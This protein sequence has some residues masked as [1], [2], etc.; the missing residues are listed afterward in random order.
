MTAD[1]RPGRAA[2]GRLQGRAGPLPSLRVARLPLG[3][4]HADLPQAEEARGRHLGLR[5]APS[6]ASKAGSSTRTTAPPAISAVRLDDLYQVYL[7]ADPHYSG[8]VTVPVLW[9]KKSETIVS[10]ESAEIIRMFNSA[11]DEFGRRVARLLSGRRCAARSTRSTTC[12][13]ETVNN[14]VYKAGFATT[15]E[16]YEEAFATLFE[17]L[18]ELEQRLSR[19]RYL[20]GDPLTEAD[21]R[22][23]TTLMRF[24]AVYIGHFKCNLAASP[25][26]RTCRAICATST[27]CRASRRRS[28]WSTSSS[29]IT[30]AT[31]RINPT[32]IVPVGPGLDFDAPHDRDRM[33]KAA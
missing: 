26:T 30:T 27:R 25:T 3:A 5:R 15:Q 24:D 11:F 18:D 14:G 22:L 28:T 4:P 33:K 7:K 23:F 1:G 12:V 32:R 8:R 31:R 19:Q 29:T 2:R 6:W 13:Y 17:T 10:N 21:W 9:D 20:I 16:A